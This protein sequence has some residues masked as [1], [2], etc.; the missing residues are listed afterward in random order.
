MSLG[1]IILII[2]VI[3]LLGGFSGC[4]CL[5]LG[6]RIGCICLLLGNRLCGLLLGI[7]NLCCSRGRLLGGTPCAHDAEGAVAA[8]RSSSASGSGPAATAPSASC[9]LCAP[10]PRRRH[11]T[12]PP[13]P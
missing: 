11:G 6:D 2:L 5:L 1:T 3:A 12:P 7:R 4:I 10:V 8:G 9:V 13:V